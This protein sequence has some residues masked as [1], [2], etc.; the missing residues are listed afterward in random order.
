MKTQLL[1]DELLST[2]VQK[3]ISD[4]HFKMLDN[5]HDVEVV[6]RRHK[7]FVETRKIER[8][9]YDFLKA[10][11]N[12][13]LLDYNRPQTGCFSHVIDDKRYLFRLSVM[14]NFVIKTAVL[15]LLNLASF[16]DLKE[17]V[18]DDQVYRKLK[19][20]SQ[21]DHGLILFCGPT[22]SGKSTTLFYFLKSLKGRQCYCLDNPIEMYDSDLVQIEVGKY[23]KLDDALQQLLRHDPDVI[24]F[25]EIRNELELSSL[26]K[27]A[28][29]GHFVCASI[30]AQQ[31]PDLFARL[32]DL[33]ASRYEIYH[34]LKGAVFQK[35]RWDD[36]K[37]KPIVSFDIYTSMEI[38]EKII[39][40]TKH[41]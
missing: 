25:G 39:F 30:H 18:Q 29:S 1:L 12:L 13:E 14:E 19:E 7:T 33:G 2:M 28:L 20:L 34:L 32:Y 16:H 22:G 8:S 40:E 31:L 27:A 5:H 36:E 23:L 10:Y 24:A 15:R 4:A 11:S 6:F 9:L 38:Q 3:R 17:C 21:L 41:P 37:K 35:M 26:R